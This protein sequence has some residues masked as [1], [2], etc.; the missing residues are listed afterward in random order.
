MTAQ[1]AESDWSDREKRLQEIRREANEIGKGQLKV[2]PKYTSLRGKPPAVGYYGTPVLK[3]PQWTVEVPIYFFVG[4]MAGAASVIGAVGQF[5]SSDRRMIRNSRWLAAIGGLISPA[6]LISDLGLPSRFL[7]MLRVFKIQSPMSV[8]SWTLVAF[9]NSAVA[10][11]VLGELEMRS[12]NGAVRVLTN[13][14]QIASAVTGIVLST[15]TG[16]LIGAAAIPVWNE[17]IST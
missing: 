1:L 4:G 17:H 10:T 13:A 9:S 12:P 8:G 14:A 2:E 11:A 6:L 3:K 16:V 7:N 15:Y 5:S